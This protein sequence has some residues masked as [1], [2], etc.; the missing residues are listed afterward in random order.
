MSEPPRKRAKLACVTCNARRVKCD[1]TERQPCSNC[2]AGNALCETRES[3]RGKHPRKPRVDTDAREIV[4]VQG[5][6]T[7]NDKFILGKKLNYAE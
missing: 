2:I 4:Y 5:T 7:E 1:V 6:L 3:K